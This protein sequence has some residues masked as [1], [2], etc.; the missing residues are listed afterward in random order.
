MNILL[1]KSNYFWN[2]EKN[3]RCIHN[4]SLVH[5]QYTAGGSWSSILPHDYL[6]FC[7]E[8]LKFSKCPK[9]DEG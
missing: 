3:K 7:K 2:I 9:I 6:G 8:F 1:N 4:I 5:P